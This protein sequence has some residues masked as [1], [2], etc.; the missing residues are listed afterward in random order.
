MTN[1]GVVDTARAPRSR[2][3]SSGSG[4]VNRALSA[5]TNA[6]WGWECA[7]SGS[8]REVPGASPRC[9]ETPCEHGCAAGFRPRWE[10]DMSDLGRHTSPVCRRPHRERDS[11]GRP[12][13]GW[14]R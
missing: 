10:I 14:R 7:F 1:V 4:V 8:E 12:P 3:L 6:H 11:R 2:G 9:G 5:Y 13:E